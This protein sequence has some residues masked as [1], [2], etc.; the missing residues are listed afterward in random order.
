MGPPKRASRLSSDSLETRS[1]SDTPP[2]HPEQPVSVLSTIPSSGTE[3]VK[4]LRGLIQLQHQVASL[5]LNGQYTPPASQSTPPPSHSAQANLIGAG[6]ERERTPSV[7]DREPSPRVNVNMTPHES[8]RRSSSSSSS[9]SSSGSSSTTSGSSALRSIGRSSLRNLIAS[10]T[11]GQGM[12]DALEGVQKGLEA[13]NA[14]KSEDIPERRIDLVTMQQ[15]KFPSVRHRSVSPRRVSAQPPTSPAAIPSSMVP[16]ERDI[17]QEYVPAYGT[18]INTLPTRR[19]SSP[20]QV[21]PRPPSPVQPVIRAP[22]P[23]PHRPVAEPI[24]AQPQAQAPAQRPSPY[25]PPPKMRV[26]DPQPDNKS[27]KKLKAVVMV[28]KSP[29]RLNR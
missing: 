16:Q 3:Q 28:L 1:E 24:P 15:D 17:T 7:G 27:P 29:P 26:L 2:N 11:P 21:Q 4:G 5:N 25:H 13:L 8:Y 20:P 18:V 23:I 22:S 6:Y 12:A 14:K 9:S 19:K 10:T